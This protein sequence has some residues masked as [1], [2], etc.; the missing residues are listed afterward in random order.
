MDIRAYLEEKRKLVEDSL[1]RCLPREDEE[2]GVLHRAMRYTVF[3][4]GKRIRPVLT[5]ATNEC[6]GGGIHRALPVACA[7][8]LIHSYSLIHDDLP[9]MDN[10]DYRRGKPASHIVF[11]EAVAILAGDALLTEAFRL[12]TDT[13]LNPGLSCELLLDIARDAAMAVG[14]LG[15]VG[16]QVADLRV[17]PAKAD[18]GT[19]ESIHS[20]K[21]GCLIQLAVKAGA[22]LGNATAE[23]FEAL[24]S[25]GRNLGLAFQISD[26]LL[27]REKE[28]WEEERKKV[29]HPG[30]AGAPASRGRLRDIIEESL[31][32]LNQFDSGADPLREIA[33]L[34]MLR[35][36]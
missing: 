28:G 20:L 33:K 36:G 2:P 22:R 18:L 15:M 5:L 31:A 35:A 6:L 34:I 27:D 25:Y 14:S 21:T 26:D 1:D 24:S 13:E 30:I 19:V 32:F 4:G 11:G 16:G 3:A 9:A 7:M 23:Q 29:T 8:E 12:L 17:D 10:D